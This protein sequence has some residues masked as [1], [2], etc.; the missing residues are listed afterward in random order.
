MI[1][2]QIQ[3]SFDDAF[4]NTTYVEV[5]PQEIGGKLVCDVQYISDIH[6]WDYYVSYTYVN[7]NDTIPIGN[8]R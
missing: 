5:I 2:E 4:E 3:E 6:S 1:K 7:N 8:G